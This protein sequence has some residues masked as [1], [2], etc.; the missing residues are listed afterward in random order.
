M[1]RVISAN[2]DLAQKYAIGEVVDMGAVPSFYDAGTSKW[3]AGGVWFA[4]SAVGE[5]VAALLALDPSNAAMTSG[6]QSSG[7]CYTPMAVVGTVSIRAYNYGTTNVLVYSNAG[8][9]SINTGITSPNGVHVVSDGT[10]FYAIAATGS[11]TV[12][13]AANGIAKSTDGVTWTL[14][15]ITWPA[16]KGL[17]NY[18]NHRNTS[19]TATGMANYAV[20]AK[21][22][23]FWAGTR[24]IALCA[25]GTNFYALRS[26]NGITWTDDSTAVLGVPSV[27]APTTGYDMRWSR[28][29]NNVFISLSG[30][31]R[32]SSDGGATW[33]AVAGVNADCSSPWQKSA[34]GAVLVLSTSS[35]LSISVNAGQTWTDRAAALGMSS[36]S[37]VAICKVASTYTIVAGHS[38]YG[39][40]KSTDG[41]ATWSAINLP[42]GIDGAIS[43]VISD[44]V[45]LYLD[46]N[47]YQT[48]V[49]TDGGATWTLRISAPSGT[50]STF[51]KALRLSVNTV[52]L[53]STSALAWSNDN[54]VTWKMCS[55]VNG[56]SITYATYAAIT[57]TTVPY[58]HVA[59][60]GGNQSCTI[61]ETELIA[62]PQYV[63][64]T[65]TAPT[66][67][68][69]NTSPRIRVA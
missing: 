64:G 36:V 8:V 67:L 27:T 45:N 47:L 13:G 29:G 51:T 16:L 50:F 2:A 55:L 7:E 43:G 4:R 10:S 28:S 60:N 19:E 21:G 58:L 18:S 59:G 23:V 9:Q 61:S 24:F 68:R 1:S 15:N 26:S 6:N 62:G 40:K 12:P 32:F 56:S 46:T 54:G 39:Y 11:N 33:S 69:G 30:A 20:A 14:Q 48:L 57:S 42:I 52:V 44:G 35:Y 49:S 37:Y 66:A 41:G 25:D 53:V 63:R 5:A 38:S 22:C 34:D 31:Y 65:A 17:S 3:V